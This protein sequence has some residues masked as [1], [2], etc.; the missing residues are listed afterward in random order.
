MSGIDFFD[1]VQITLVAGV[2]TVHLLLF[3]FYMISKISERDDILAKSR[4]A[5]NKADRPYWVVGCLISGSIWM[6]ATLLISGNFAI[7]E[8]GSS[9][10]TCVSLKVVFQYTFGYI[11][12]INL[13]IYRLF[14]LYMVHSWVV[15]PLHAMIVLSLLMAPFIIYS[16]IALAFES[17][18]LPSSD[19]EGIP[20]CSQSLEWSIPFYSL[21]LLYMVVFIFLAVKV[22]QITGT[23]KDLRRYITFCGVSFVFLIF[24]AS[25]NLTDHWK[26]ITIRRLLCFFVFCIVTL[27]SWSIFW[28]VLIRR[29]VKKPKDCDNSSN[30]EGPIMVSDEKMVNI[31]A[32]NF[33]EEE[34]MGGPIRR[35]TNVDISDYDTEHCNVR[36]G[37]RISTRPR[38]SESEIM[39]PD[40]SAFTGALTSTDLNRLETTNAF[41]EMGLRSLGMN[42]DLDDVNA[43][44][45]ILT[46][47]GDK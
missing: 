39:T 38:E 43:S 12:W 32:P 29:R 31:N 44:L 11:L 1:I 45:E 21:A 41:S 30:G 25:M 2:C 15:K 22:N 23:F 27:Q 36:Q 42:V 5:Q 6:V 16:I 8:Q 47:K 14:R 9:Y 7:F 4:S 10:L 46:L 3:I 17:N 19:F 35:T 20:T 33:T 34:L 37:A 40:I 18:Y 28:S 13:I 26:L 24:D